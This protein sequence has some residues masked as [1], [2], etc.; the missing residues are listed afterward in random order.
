LDNYQNENIPNFGVAPKFLSSGIGL[1]TNNENVD[2]IELV[3]YTKPVLKATSLHDTGLDPN[4]I[5]ES[6]KNTEFIP[7]YNIGLMLNNLNA[8]KTEPLHEISSN[9]KSHKS[10]NDN[11]NSGFEKFEEFTGI[12]E[13]VNE[14]KQLLVSNQVLAN[15][16]KDSNQELANAIKDSNQ[17]LANEIKDSNQVLAIEIKFAVKAMN[18]S[19]KNQT[20]LTSSIKSL[21]EDLRKNKNN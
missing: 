2:K 14:L 13:I 17:I 15:E 21:V 5:I 10:S 3:D 4:F 19:V 12:D 16:I 8:S 9:K 18:D 20:E 1:S 6:A 11:N 7:F